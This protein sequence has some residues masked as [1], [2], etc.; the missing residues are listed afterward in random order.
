MSKPFL[1]RLLSYL[2]TLW[3]VLTLNFL[4]PRL[5][6][7]DPLD[8][9]F[10]RDAAGYVADE[11]VRGRLA[12]YYGLDRP[13]GQQ[14]LA[15]LAGAAQGDLG[16]SIWLNR[17]VGELIA[18]RLPWTLLLTLTSLT[19][20]SLI[21]IWLGAEA[22][23]HRGS[24]GDRW[25]VIAGIVASNAPVYVVGVGLLILFGARL[26]WL[27]LA[28]GRTAFASYPHALAAAGDVARHLILPAATLTLH[29]VGAKLLLIRNS[30]VSVLGEDFMLVARAKGL[31]E[32]RLKRSHALRNALLPFVAQLGAQ[33]G[34][35]VTGAIF[36]ET[37]FAYPGMGRLIFDAVAV[38]DYPLLQGAFLVVAF[39]VLTANLLADEINARLD[40][41]VGSG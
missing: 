17:P 24:R 18:G 15:Y 13:L 34:M 41:R 5:L 12:A 25:A 36:I 31:A 35:A 8:A 21:G 29:L 22:G 40:P 23:W 39:V 32:V 10:D 19:L 2:L 27:P 7:G 4:L 9:L 33:M 30:M 37:V 11:A 1:R 6:P 38:R 26:G 28:G 20:A 14:Y 16:W 3:V